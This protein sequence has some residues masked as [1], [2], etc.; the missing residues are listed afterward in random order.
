MKKFSIKKFFAIHVEELYKYF[1]DSHL[2]EKWAYPDGMSLKI[3]KFHPE[4]NSKYRYEH[5]GKD[6]LYVCEGHFEEIVP[7]RRIIQLDEFV[8]GPNAKVIYNNLRCVIEFNE[9][10]DGTEVTVTQSG[11]ESDRGLEA[12]RVGWTQCLDRLFDLVEREIGISAQES[13]MMDEGG[14][15]PSL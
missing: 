12:S 1:M 4:V 8:R 6:G 7:E 9:N 14:G 2:L 13:R 10:I 3:T 11:F 15:Q 5:S